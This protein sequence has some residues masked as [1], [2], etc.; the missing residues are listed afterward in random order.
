MAGVVLG[1]AIDHWMP[2]AQSLP[3]AV[4]LWRTH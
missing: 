4:R 3:H 2:E 1:A